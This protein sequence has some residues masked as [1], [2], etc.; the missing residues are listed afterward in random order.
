MR[1]A[2]WPIPE[3]DV[4]LMFPTD[5]SAQGFEDLKDVVD[6]FIR[7]QKREHERKLE[8]F[9]KVEASIEAAQAKNSE[10]EN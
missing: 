4:I 1:K 10:E 3:G 6:M 2:V 5:L 8:A 7:Q 9:K